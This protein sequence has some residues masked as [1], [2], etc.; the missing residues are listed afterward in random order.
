MSHHFPMLPS[1]NL[2]RSSRRERRLR[3]SDPSLLQNIHLVKRVNQPIFE[4]PLLPLCIVSCRFLS[5]L[6]KYNYVNFQVMLPR[7]NPNFQEA[8]SS[9]FLQC[10]NR[11]DFVFDL[12]HR[13][14]PPNLQRLHKL[15]TYI[16][17]F[18]LAF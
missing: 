6:S 13:V 3:L 18:S 15:I 14:F 8:A 7:I 2:L 5:C 12:E 4:K 9:K 11:S 10:L 17:P 16:P 1:S